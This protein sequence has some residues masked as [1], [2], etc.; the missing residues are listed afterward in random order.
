VK[1]K[2]YVTLKKSV[3]D[4]QGKA[5]QHAIATSGIYELKDVRMG[6]FI[7]LDLGNVDKMEADQK[8]K[9]MCEKLLANTVIE[10]YRYE[11][12]Q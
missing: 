9:E 7:E 10:E 5:V 4:P 2:V 3:L 1:A 11:L 8:V 12:N 6:K